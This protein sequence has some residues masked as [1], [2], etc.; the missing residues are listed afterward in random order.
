[1]SVNFIAERK[2]KTSM[3]M[4]HVKRKTMSSLRMNKGT[5]YVVGLEVNFDKFDWDLQYL[6]NVPKMVF[7]VEG[8]D[9]GYCA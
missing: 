7:E 5:I 2:K 3:L 4:L 1:M 8:H 6:D 9:I